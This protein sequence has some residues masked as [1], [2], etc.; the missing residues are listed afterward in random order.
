M[1]HSYSGNPAVNPTSVLLPDDTDPRNASSVNVPFEALQDHAAHVT[2][3][4]DSTGVD[5]I[6]SG[7]FAAMI[8]TASPVT[9]SVW[10]VPGYGLYTYDPASVVPNDGLL[11][12]ASLSGGR[13]VH[14]LA[15]TKNGAP[16]GLASAL[17]GFPV[18]GSNPS[19]PGKIP[20]STVTYAT[21][22]RVAEAPSQH[23]FAVP[24]GPGVVITG[25]QLQDIDVAPLDVVEVSF[26]GLLAYEGAAATAGLVRLAYAVDV[27]GAGNAILRNSGNFVGAELTTST[28]VYRKFEPVSFTWRRI[29]QTTDNEVTF[30]ILTDPGVTGTGPWRLYVDSFVTTVTR[31]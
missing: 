16:I 15:Y 23:T 4:I 8:A 21:V 7:N 22:L 6:R 3:R 18:I 30:N 20:P 13:W 17:I 2:Q 11:V 31:Q 19:Y 28:A 12:H 9:G 14:V 5:A 10:L 27:N 26:T 1:P 25:T 29:W 24:L